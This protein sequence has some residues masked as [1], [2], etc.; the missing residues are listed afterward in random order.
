[1]KRPLK[2]VAHWLYFAGEDLRA[3]KLLC[4]E[5]IYSLACLHAQQ[6]AEKLL[7]AFIL[8]QGGNFK[9]IHDLNELLEI[10][11][12]CGDGEIRRFEKEL[13]I[14][15]T[16]YAPMR[17]PDGVPGGLVDRMPNKKDADEAIE[18][19]D[20][21]HDY[22]MKVVPGIVPNKKSSK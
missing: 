9:K 20:R 15:N 13:S 16:F 10:C 6:C 19:A 7:K 5:E 1:M 11:V 3:A 8:F 2:E 17:Y 22:V 21:L 18:K 12:S 4:K 14:L